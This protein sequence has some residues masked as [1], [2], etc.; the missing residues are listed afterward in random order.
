MTRHSER[1]REREKQAMEKRKIKREKG[2]EASDSLCQE[3]AFNK[4]LIF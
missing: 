1:A 2:K 4:L 3:M